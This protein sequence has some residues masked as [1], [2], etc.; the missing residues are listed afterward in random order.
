MSAQIGLA[1]AL[2]YLT[3]CIGG[4]SASDGAAVAVATAASA[5][6]SAALPMVVMRT[7]GRPLPGAILAFS[8]AENS[9]TIAYPKT[10]T[11]AGGRLV[12]IRQKGTHGC[13]RPVVTCAAWATRMPVWI[14]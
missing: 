8:F 10:L 9:I 13:V 2:T 11:F 12:P 7:S 1:A 4:S 6:P 14:G 5:T 3:W